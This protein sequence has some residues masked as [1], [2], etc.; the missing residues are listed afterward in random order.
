[1]TF[2]THPDRTASFTPEE[3]LKASERFV[4]AT[5]AYANLQ[6]RAGHIEVNQFSP[7]FFLGRISQLF[8]REATSA[9]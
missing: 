4:Q 7:T 9:E 3:Q 5:S 8:N 2:Q 1:M 6:E